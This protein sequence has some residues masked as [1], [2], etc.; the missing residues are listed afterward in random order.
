MQRSR[1]LFASLHVENF[2]AWNNALKTLDASKVAALYVPSGLSFLPT[3]SADHIK[4]EV[5][6]KEY[7][8]G[9]LK[10]SPEATI[11][12]EDVKTFG[13]DAYLHS[14]MYTFHLGPE[15]SPVSARFSYMWEKRDG[16]WLISHHHSSVAPA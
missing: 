12:S 13:S 10:K 5:A 3:L 1:V 7:F 16:K 6:T 4:E 9:L 8:V 11:T 14:G 15:R 2:A